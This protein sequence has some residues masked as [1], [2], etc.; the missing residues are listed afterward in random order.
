MAGLGSTTVA[1][2]TVPRD[3]NVEENVILAREFR[4]G[5]A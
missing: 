4:K 3:I 2:P 5:P 1:Y